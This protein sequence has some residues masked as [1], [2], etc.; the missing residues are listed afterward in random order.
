MSM[1]ANGHKSSPNAP[2]MRTILQ[3]AHGSIKTGQVMGVL[4]PSGSGKSTLLGILTGGSSD[5]PMNASL[6]GDLMLDG[7]AATGSYKRKVAFVPQAEYLLPTLTV[8]EC[9]WYSAMLRLPKSVSRA[10]VANR[11]DSVLHEVGL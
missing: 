2:N 1:P 4:G 7:T 3:D 6:A 11:A 9:V 10:E 8:R 5:L